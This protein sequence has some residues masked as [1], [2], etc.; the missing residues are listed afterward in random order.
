MDEKLTALTEL[1]RQSGDAHHQAFLATNGDDEDWAIW[2]ADYL[3][4][5]L[6]QHLGTRLSR[7]ELVYA[8]KRLDYEI[9]EEKPTEHWSAYYAKRLVERYPAG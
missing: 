7:S 4:D 3:Y 9:R 5:K 2:Y 6:P 1:M 8:L